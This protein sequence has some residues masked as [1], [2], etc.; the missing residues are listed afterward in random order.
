MDSGLVD[1]SGNNYF[2]SDPFFQLYIQNYAQKRNAQERNLKKGFVTEFSYEV[3]KTTTDIRKVKN[4]FTDNFTDNMNKILKLIESNPNISQ[5]EM[6]DK[7]G[8]SKRAIANNT[9]KLKEIGVLERVGSAKGGYW[10]IKVK[11]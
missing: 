9:N 11:N 8:I 6:A 4:N 1:K 2:I 10:K 3:Q 5:I 7:L